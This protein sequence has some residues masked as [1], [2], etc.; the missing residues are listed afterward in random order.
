MAMQKKNGFLF[1]LP[2]KWSPLRVDNLNLIKHEIMF[3]METTK[4]LCKSF[5]ILSNAKNVSACAKWLCKYLVWLYIYHE[6]NLDVY[7]TIQY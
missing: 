5:W 3:L 7:L 6:F 1:V 4:H 2:Y